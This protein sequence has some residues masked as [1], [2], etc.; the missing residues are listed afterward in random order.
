RSRSLAGEERLLVLRV[1]RRVH[2]RERGAV[3]RGREGPVVDFRERE[4]PHLHRSALFDHELLHLGRAHAAALALEVYELG[5][6]EAA[7]RRADAGAFRE[8]LASEDRKSTR[9]NSS[10]VAISYAVFCLKKKKKNNFRCLKLR[11]RNDSI[12]T[13]S[14]THS[15]LLPKPATKFNKS[16]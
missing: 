2:V 15:S 3:L 5:D 9:L 4:K 11:R 1:E 16:R 6:V 7:L 14:I 12:K 13:E 8:Q 10:H